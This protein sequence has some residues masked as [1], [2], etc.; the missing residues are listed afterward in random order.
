MENQVFTSPTREW[1]FYPVEME[2]IV[3][4]TSSAQES[5]HASDEKIELLE[6][7]LAELRSVSAGYEEHLSAVQTALQ[8]AKMDLVQS[9]TE[10]KDEID[11]LVCNFHYI[12]TRYLCHGCSDSF[13]LLDCS[14]EAKR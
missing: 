11:N 13:L 7:S 6:K 9:R 5:Q 12:V 8:Q 3:E 4:Q 10:A 1:D 2:P 14:T